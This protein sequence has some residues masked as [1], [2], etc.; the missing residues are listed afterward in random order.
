MNTRI[1][2]AC[3]L[4]AALSVSAVSSMSAAT[5]SAQP[6][7][8]VAPEY[9][10]LLR[11]DLVE[12]RVVVEFTITKTGSVSDARVVSSTNR[13]LDAPT[14]AAIRKWTFTPETRDGV[15][16][17]SVAIQ[18]VAYTIPEFHDASATRIIVAAPKAPSRASAL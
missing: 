14:L 10:P 8:Q 7:S 4:A 17:N 16:V 15:A 9:S 6:V 11:A 3:S 2:S 13:R 5:Q 12:G 1:I 18:P